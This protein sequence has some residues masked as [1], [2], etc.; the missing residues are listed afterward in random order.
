MINKLEDGG[1]NVLNETGVSCDRCQR[2]AHMYV[3]NEQLSYSYWQPLNRW[4]TI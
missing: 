3:L 1:D 4:I 2:I